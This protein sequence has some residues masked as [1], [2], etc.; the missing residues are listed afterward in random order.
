[1][2]PRGKKLFVFGISFELVDERFEYA[3][4]L[5]TAMESLRTAGGRL[6]KNELEKRHA[7]EMEDYERARHKK[8][9][10]EQFRSEV[11]RQLK[12]E[13]LMETNGVRYL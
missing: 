7:I 10:M 9:Q 13:E 12:I 6:G 3:R 5:K 2:G 8:Q 11:Y 4:K 1:M